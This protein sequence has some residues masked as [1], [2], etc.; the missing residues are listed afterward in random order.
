YD[1]VDLDECEKRKIAVYNVPA[2]STASVTEL[3][4][5]LAVGLLREIPKADALVRN[6]EWEMKPGLELAGRKIGIF[7]TGKIGLNTA[8][9]FKALGGELV[10]CSRTEKK[11]FIEMG[12]TYIG[13]KQE[14]FSAVDIVSVHVPLNEKTKG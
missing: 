1:S 4:I 8:K 2:Y 7:G 14:F 10:G 12:G 6:G 13:D 9:V 5:G 3:S 11:E